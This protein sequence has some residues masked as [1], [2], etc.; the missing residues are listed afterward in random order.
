MQKATNLKFE[1][2]IPWLITL[3]N[4]PEAE[5]GNKL[6]QQFQIKTTSCQQF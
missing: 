5:N 4:N 2:P 3:W 6:S 1:I